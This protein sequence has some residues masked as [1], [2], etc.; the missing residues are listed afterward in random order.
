[1]KD[2]KSA[3]PEEDF[4]SIGANESTINSS[5]GDPILIHRKT[6]VSIG[7]AL[8]LPEKLQASVFVA[9]SLPW[10]RSHDVSEGDSQSL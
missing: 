10:R 8:P 1:M 9:L 3:D 6:C 4:Y 7:G 2:L 5:Q